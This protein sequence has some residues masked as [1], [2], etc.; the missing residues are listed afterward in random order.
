MMDSQDQTPI[1][2]QN[3]VDNAAVEEQPVVDL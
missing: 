1:E 3:V 2:E